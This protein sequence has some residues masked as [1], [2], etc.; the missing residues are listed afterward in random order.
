MTDL[1]AI[2]AQLVDIQ[3]DRQHKGSIK[4]TIHVPAEQGAELTAAF[5]WP[6]HT[7]PVPVALARLDLNKIKQTGVATPVEGDA[8]GPSTLAVACKASAS[9]S[10]RGQP[11]RKSWHEMEPS[12]QAGILCA[13]KTFQAFLA[14]DLDVEPG[15]INEEFA[16]A[17]VC[18]RCGVNSRSDIKTGT[19]ASAFW[20]DLVSDYRAWC[21][22][23]EVVG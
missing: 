4:V 7:N 20:R 21:H 5:G 14:A 18:A 1:A 23:P 12:Q 19:I 2:A 10:G 9:E 6:T 13:D 22:E 15:I 17:E 11:S 8:P 16:K 3:N